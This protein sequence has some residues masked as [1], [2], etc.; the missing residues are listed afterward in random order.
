M[1]NQ[2]K[3]KNLPKAISIV[4]WT[5]SI[6]MALSF[7]SPT[8]YHLY[9]SFT[10]F[11]VTLFDADFESSNGDNS[12]TYLG[13]ASDGNWERAIPTP[14]TTGGIQM[15]IAAYQGQRD[16]LTGNNFSQD[17]DGG[18]TRAYSR[19]IFLAPGSINL[20][21]HYYF[22]Y[23][24]NS[25]NADFFQ[26][27]LR[28]ASDDALLAT[29]L[30]ERGSNSGR[31]AQWTAQNIDLTA[32]SGNTVYLQV[33]ARDISNGSKVEAA[34]DEIVIT[35]TVPTN[36]AGN[37]YDDLNNNSLLD[38]NEPGLA[39]V[40]V[41]LFDD[42]GLVASTKTNASGNYLFS[43]LPVG[44]AFR[45]EFSAFPIGYYESHIGNQSSSSIQFVTTGNITAHLGLLYEE[46][47]CQDN[48]PII[49]PCYVEGLF[50]GP[51]ANDVSIVT[52]PEQADGHDF[53]GVNPTTDYEG[54]KITDHIETGTVYGVAWQASK[55]KFYASAFHKRYTGF[56]PNG[57]DAIYQMDIN[58]NISG[59]IELD[60]LL[61][62]SN[63]TGGD[64]HNFTPDPNGEIYDLG[65]FDAS[66]DAVGKRA[67]G[68][69]ELSPD[70]NALYVVNLWNRQLYV[71]DVST[72][73]VNQ[74]EVTTSYAL[75]DETNASRHRPFGLGWYD[76]KLWV[77]SVDENSTFAYVHSMNPTNGAFTLELTVPL[78]YTRQAIIGDTG[79]PADASTWRPWAT[80]SSLPYAAFG[81][82]IGYPQPMLTDLEF[83]PNGNMILGFRDRFGDQS[84]PEKFFRRGTSQRTWGV[85][86]G[87]ILKACL[88]AGSYQLETG[89]NGP[90]ATIGGL[91][92]SG[93]N[94]QH[95]FYFWDIWDFENVTWNPNVTNGA[96][97]WEITQ[98]GLLQLPRNP[99]VIT[100]SQDPFDD[101]SGGIIKLDNATGARYEMDPVSNPFSDVISG[102]TVYES[103]DYTNQL[104]PNI[105]TASKANGLG[106]L[107]AGCIAPL[108]IGNYVWFDDDKDGIQD[109]TEPPLA[110]V[111]VSLYKNGILVG[112]VSTDQ[113]G[114]YVFG[115][116][117][118]NGMLNDEFIERFETYEV[119]I[120]MADAIANDG[121]IVGIQS[122]TTANVSG[123]SSDLIDSD[124]LLSTNGLFVYAS[125]TT[126]AF[127]HNDF[128]IDFGFTTCANSTNSIVYTGCS[129]DGYSV[130]VNGNIYDVN[131]PSGTET[132]TNAEG[133]DSIITIDLTFFPAV[134]V[135]A[136]MRAGPLCSNEN[137]DLQSLGASIS[138]GIAT[139]TWTSMGG[140]FFDNGGLFGRPV[141]ATTY[142]L[143]SAELDAGFIILTLTSDIPPGPCEPQAD[144]VLIFINDL[145]CSTFPYSGNN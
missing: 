116:N 136:G 120:L 90:C 68:D 66:L 12:W 55:R 110:D 119:R 123:N 108:S 39:N 73:D 124:G 127:G 91:P 52:L 36:I 137:L 47:L 59:V 89:I 88:I 104:P 70:M 84:G 9:P 8:N 2:S 77:G 46:N 44:Q 54:T 60:G 134:V 10:P 74:I 97:H 1:L 16:L 65:R 7:V 93:P 34:I 130:V 21:F 50:N 114:Y 118:D 63:S 6:F 143:S 41:Q 64:V 144:A 129:D 125:V 51:L 100:T 18:P 45:L 69:I 42:L 26:L 81:S 105:G 4:F 67:F 40:T 109:P 43:G 142:T 32:Y 78:N 85:A 30:D 128:S 72:G 135:E 98:G 145:R 113:R 49:I 56:G 92:N 20:S 132:L 57:P 22:S 19:D 86:A 71:L 82:E 33:V 11:M 140:G 126:G 106:D 27:E 107:E 13:G 23:Y 53:V 94:G 87:D 131:N 117:N 14:Y 95:E 28:D 58:G 62:I 112:Q 96:F 38:T 141:S 101:F 76:D 121:S 111:T 31:A 5:S 79:D 48:P 3:G 115:G 17:V 138:G 99:Y 122:N 25:S 80:N 24:T 83:E 35:Q 61:G 139:G 133:C 102:Y 15:E 37:V 103:G 29:L 75:P